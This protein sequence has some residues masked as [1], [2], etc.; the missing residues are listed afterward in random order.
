MSMQIIEIVE[1]KVSMYGCHAEPQIAC[2][3]LQTNSFV[4]Q[5]N[6]SIFQKR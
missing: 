1:G 5:A 6:V 3:T 2:C 4:N